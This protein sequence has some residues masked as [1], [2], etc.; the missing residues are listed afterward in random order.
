MRGGR[1]RLQTPGPRARHDTPA[2]AI[3]I[4]K[5]SLIESLWDVV[6]VD[7]VR[8]SNHGVGGGLLRL[9]SGHGGA[10]DV[11]GGVVGE[12][13]ASGGGAGSA[14]VAIERAQDPARSELPSER[15]TAG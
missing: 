11:S 5:D 8:L 12:D 10:R 13:A 4:A 3:P 6:S 2:Q 14:V 9:W 7:F 1:E 15:R